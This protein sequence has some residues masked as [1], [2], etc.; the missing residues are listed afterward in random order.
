MILAWQDARRK[1]QETLDHYWDGTFPVRVSAISKKMGV[2]PYRATLPMGVSGMIIK[3]QGQEA[4]SYA[5]ANESEERRRFTL[6]HELGHYVERVTLA[7][8]NDFAFKDKREPGQYNL[9]EFAAHAREAVHGDGQRGQK[10]HRD[11]RAVRGVPRRREEEKGTVDHQPA[12][13]G[14]RR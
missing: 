2:T 4:R 6:A 3:E 11:R 1:A 13:A 14:G 5:D 10:P 9:H 12:R 7:E 8:D